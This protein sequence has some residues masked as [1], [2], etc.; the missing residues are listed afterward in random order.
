ME[1]G[2]ARIEVSGIG[3]EYELLGEAG[4]HAV[5]L[6]PGGRF[7]KDAPGMRELAD[8]LVA[9]GKRVLLWDRPNCGA[10]DMCF[11]GESESRLQGRVLIELVRA[12]GLGKVAVA[13]GS[14]GARTTMFA[15]AHDP[16]A[17]SHMIPWWISAGTICLLSL[18][19]AYCS[20]PAVAASMGGMEAVTRLPI[21]AEQLRRNPRN[22]EILLSQ[23]AD[24]FIAVM[25]QWAKAF[26]PPP[27]AP[28]PG[29]TQADI[30]RLT[31]PVLIFRSSDRDLYHPGWV[32]DH[33]HKLIP[34]SKMVASPWTDE[35]FVKRMTSADGHFLDW[36]RLAPAIV[37]FTERPA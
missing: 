7:S 20:D 30:A 26:A 15:A 29:M 12:L 33:V 9:G 10:S 32:T 27:D 19:A 22:R 31:M 14:A 28:L 34:H 3:I 21:F 24:Q 1:S 23:D 5:V 18:G 4:A 11:E 37:E 13:G 2:V 8:A 25:Q 16:E 17:V 36:H 35:E 6:S